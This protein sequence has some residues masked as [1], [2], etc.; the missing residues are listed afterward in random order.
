MKLFIT[1]VFWFIIITSFR[2]E[3]VIASKCADYGLCF[4]NAAECPPAC[5]IAPPS[6]GWTDCIIGLCCGIEDTPCMPSFSRCIQ[7]HYVDTRKFLPQQ[8]QVCTTGCGADAECNLKYSG[9]FVTFVAGGGGVVFCNAEC[10]GEVLP[11]SLG[12]GS[13]CLGSNDFRCGAGRVCSWVKNYVS[14]NSGS[15]TQIAKCIGCEHLNNK[16]NE[17]VTSWT[18]GDYDPSITKTCGYCKSSRNCIIGTAYGPDSS[19]GSS[20]SCLASDW[21]WTTSSCPSGS[22]GTTAPPGSTIPPTTTPPP[23]GRC[24]DPCSN[25]VIQKGDS[26]YKLLEF[27]RSYGWD[28]SCNNYDAYKAIIDNWCIISPVD[29]P[30]AKRD[31]CGN[32]CGST[33]TTAPP[34]TTI[35]PTTIPPTTIP[36]TITLPPVTQFTLSCD[37][38][39]MKIDEVAKC[40]VKDCTSGLW[41]IVNKEKTPLDPLTHEPIIDIPPMEIEIK[42]TKTDGLIKAYALCFEPVGMKQIKQEKLIAVTGGSTTSSSTSTT[43]TQPSSNELVCHFD[44][45]FTCSGGETTDQE[46]LIDNFANGEKWQESMMTGS[47]ING[48]YQGRIVSTVDPYM[49]M[50][51]SFDESLN[52]ISMKYKG[53]PKGPSAIKIYYTDNDDTTNND[54]DEFDEKCS[55]SFPITVTSDY[56]LLSLDMIDAEW[57]DNDGLI[58]QLKIDFE[59]ATDAGTIFLDLIKASS[60]GF[61]PG[62]S[63]AGA[64]IK[65]G[66]TLTYP[67]AGNINPDKGTIDLWVKPLWNGND[68]IT[69]YLFDTGAATDSNRLSIYKDDDQ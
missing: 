19:L 40:S 43:T 52:H 28:I 34:P 41:I 16:C 31:L 53:Y 32:V 4:S 33:S 15:Y 29:C 60:A 10:K 50:P 17:C 38:E 12:V 42:P 20:Y 56:Q 61:A 69:H 6:G 49:F 26:Q 25:C 55:Q 64:V 54:C 13:T 5:G 1:I 45:S 46:I 62:K 8:E 58:N 35:P 3:Y 11:S 2:F 66:N 27:Y 24:T 67:T 63:D 51:T 18:S 7:G 37:K 23:S 21:V 48:E 44:N 36:P 65:T 57:I 59:S 9:E 14:G 39:S 30:N 47:T 68:G 22:T